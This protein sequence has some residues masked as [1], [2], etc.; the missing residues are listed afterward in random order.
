MVIYFSLIVFSIASLQYFLDLQI[1]P[2]VAMYLAVVFPA[3]ALLF[4]EYKKPFKETW[5]PDFHYFVQDLFYLLAIQVIFITVV[6]YSLLYFI[7]T[8]GYENGVVLAI[9]PTHWPLFV[10]LICMILL[11]EFFQYWWHRISHSNPNLWAL[12]S[13]HHHPDRVYSLNTARFHL[14]DKAVEFLVDIFIFLLMGATAELIA[15]YYV[16]YAVN[17]LLQHA[18]LKIKLGDFN[19]VLASVENHRLHHDFEPEMAHCNFGNNTMVWDHVFRTYRHDNHSPQMVGT[20][21][22][23][24]ISLGQQ[25]VQPLIRWGILNWIIKAKTKLAWDDIFNA[26]MTPKVSQERVLKEI[27]DSNKTTELGVRH[28]FSCI[29]SIAEYQQ[30]IEIKEFDEISEILE[31]QIKQKRPILVTDEICY[32]AKTSGTTG[33]PKRIPATEKSL[34]ILSRSQQVSIYSVLS[35]SPKLFWGD[36]FVLVDKELE[37]T[38]QSLPTGSMSGKVYGRS[39]SIIKNKNRVSEDIKQIE[40]FD[41]KY[42]VLALTAI[43]NPNVTLLS[44]ANPSTILRIVEIINLKRRQLTD[45]IEVA[46]TIQYSELTEKLITQTLAVT[47][48]WI[49]SRARIILNKPVVELADIFP[50]LAVVFCWT[51]G[52]CGYPL[53][54]VR[55]QLPDSAQVYEVGLVSSE[56]RATVNL[57]AQD[58]LCV[59]MINDYFYEFI[60]P[61]LYESGERKTKLIS[62][63]EPNTE[64]YLIVTTPMGLYRYFINDIVRTGEKVNQTYSLEFVR[65]GKGCTNITGEKLTEYDFVSFF[66]KVENSFVSFFLAVCDP[67][68]GA[69]LL[70]YEAKEPLDENVLH[71]HLCASNNEYESKVMSGRLPSIKVQRLMSGCGEAYKN[72]LGF[73]EKRDWQFKYM[74][75]IYQQDL[76]MDIQKWCHG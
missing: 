38:Y 42:F 72:S 50:S 39:P 69:Y 67:K 2:Q 10:Q 1:Y 16:F 58:N 48:D 24:P 60:E 45:T 14:L 3:L 15:F 21:E 23:R 11:G 20:E 26:T 43:L 55:R 41:E 28:Q 30:A 71:Q 7:I 6:K 17:G 5:K 32:L 22:V 56:Y 29:N 66:S 65:K 37:E 53:E 31:L 44:T 51:K 34:E 35:Q 19:F 27:L 25:I 4:L 64:Y 59:P 9:W 62:N 33:Y 40:S 47:P 52:S 8:L 73:G 75:L 54:S 74:H 36:A 18:N 76:P 70:Y 49:R 13:I 68:Q 61:D 12:H 57:I 46:T 63:L